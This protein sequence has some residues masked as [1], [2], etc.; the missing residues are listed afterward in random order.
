MC[1]QWIMVFPPSGFGLSRV[2]PRPAPRKRE[3]PPEAEGDERAAFTP[4]RAALA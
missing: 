3:G 2:R 1:F 4:H